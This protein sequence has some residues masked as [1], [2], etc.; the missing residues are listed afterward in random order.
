MEMKMTKFDEDGW[1]NSRRDTD[2]EN[3]RL[4]WSCDEDGDD[5]VR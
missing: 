3:T 1:N 4:A 5:D 2:R